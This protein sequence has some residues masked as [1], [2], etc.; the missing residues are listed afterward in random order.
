MKH[1]F[2]TMCLHQ[3]VMT[4]YHSVQD[5][6]YLLSLYEAGKN[7]EWSLSSFK[8]A[9]KAY[10]ERS[11]C[12]IGL[13][14]TNNIFVLRPKM[15]ENVMFADAIS[16][17]LSLEKVNLSSKDVKWLVTNLGN[18]LEINFC[19]FAAISIFELIHKWTWEGGE[20]ILAWNRFKIQKIRVS[21]EPLSS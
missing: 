8:I 14:K 20:S 1:V 5:W 18:Y 7:A 21:Y 13:R 9:I 6:I 4:F 15:A 16:L 10:I 17:S 2:A 19:L 12:R 3:F 11:R